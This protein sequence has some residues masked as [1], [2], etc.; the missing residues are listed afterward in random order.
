MIQNLRWRF[1]QV[2]SDISE[3]KEKEKEIKQA[4]EKVKETE[5]KMSDALNSM[6]HGITMWDKDDTLVIC[7]YIL[8]K[9][10]KRCWCKI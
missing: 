3:M 1:F 10:F 4:K 2:Y 6:P 9:I 8:L 7:K 5:Q